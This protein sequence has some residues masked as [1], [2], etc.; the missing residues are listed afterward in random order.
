[1]ETYLLDTGY[2][3]A[4]DF[5]ELFMKID[6][7]DNFMNGILINRASLV[8]EGSKWQQGGGEVKNLQQQLEKVHLEDDACVITF[9]LVLSFRFC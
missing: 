5:N 4:I 8:M 7:L 9:D 3:T 6:V 2:E 1:M